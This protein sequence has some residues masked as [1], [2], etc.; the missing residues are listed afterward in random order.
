MVELYPHKVHQILE[1]KAIFMNLQAIRDQEPLVPESLKAVVFFVSKLLLN[2]AQ[3]KIEVSPSHQLEIFSFHFQLYSKLEE[4]DKEGII[5]WLKGVYN[6]SDISGV[7][8]T[9]L[10]H[11]VHHFAIN[12]LLKGIEPD[13]MRFCLGILRNLFWEQK[14]E[15]YEVVLGDEENAALFLK[16]LSDIFIEKDFSEQDFQVFLQLIEVFLQ[17]VSSERKRQILEAGDEL[18]EGFTELF[19]SKD[20]ELFRNGFLMLRLVRMN[21]QHPKLSIKLKTGELILLILERIVPVSGEELKAI[22]RNL[23]QMAA[24][25]LQSHFH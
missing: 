23:K 1:S 17:T 8:S 9:L 10:K 22:P 5:D 3:F 25:Y 11:D 21:M 15:V 14:Q 24:D 20:V 19:F 6:Y 2:F 13:M 16:A 7:E 12:V 4:D 18:P